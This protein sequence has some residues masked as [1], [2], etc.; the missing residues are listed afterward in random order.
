[1]LISCLYKH[2]TADMS[3]QSDVEGEIAFCMK[4][5]LFLVLN[6]AQRR[7]DV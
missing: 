6:K 3:V 4:I 2:I 5:K 1:M 7:A